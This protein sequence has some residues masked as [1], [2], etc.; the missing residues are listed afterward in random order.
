MLV[1]LIL[2]KLEFLFTHRYELID[3]RYELTKLKLIDN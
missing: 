3:H 2:F 1:T